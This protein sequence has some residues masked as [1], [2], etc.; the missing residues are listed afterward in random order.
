MGADEFTPVPSSTLAASAGG[1]QVC[2]NIAISGAG[3]IYRD[4]SCNTI[5]GILP[6]GGSPVSG[7][8]NTCVTIDATVQSYGGNVYVQ[9]HFDIT[10]A[11]NQTTATARITLYVLQSEFD[12]YNV[13]NGIQ[14]D[15]PTGSGDATGIANLRITKYSGNG[16]LPGTYSPGVATFINPADADIVWDVLNNWWTISF[17]ITGFS[18]FFIH[19]GSGVLPV[20]ILP[21]QRIQRWQPQPTTLDNRQRT[22]QQWFRNAAFCGWCKL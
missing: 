3:T 5:A 19:T 9:R 15:L 6:N 21:L 14:S 11:V 7:L 16:T 2:S 12:S 8:V 22:K 4:A 17:D 13:A 1:G 20:S 10:P 18:G